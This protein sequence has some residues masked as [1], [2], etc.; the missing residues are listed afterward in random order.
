MTA[1]GA[2]LYVY[3][4]VPQAAAN[5][6]V[7]AVRAMQQALCGRHAGLQAEL[8]QREPDAGQVT[9]MEVYRRAG[10]GID[11]MLAEDIAGAA[12]DVPVQAVRA[13]VRHVEV[14][15]PCA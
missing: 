1:D 8:L 3:F 6:A 9:L 7:R 13:A 12:R 5:T 4:K 10:V 2:R 14:F 15:R 11:A